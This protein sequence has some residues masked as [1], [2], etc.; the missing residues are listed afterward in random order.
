MSDNKEVIELSEQTQ[1][2]LAGLAAQIQPVQNVIQAVISTVIAEK[3]NPDKK[4]VLSE[5]GKKLI[6]WEGK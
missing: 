5:D 1:K 2:L 3:G 6:E 4:Y